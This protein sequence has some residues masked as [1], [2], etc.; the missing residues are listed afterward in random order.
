MLVVHWA[1][2]LWDAASG[3]DPPQSCLVEGIFSLGVSTGP[4]FNLYYS[5]G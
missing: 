4:E 2:I 3:I 5:I 1:C